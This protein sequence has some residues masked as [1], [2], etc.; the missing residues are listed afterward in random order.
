MHEDN[1]FFFSSGCFWFIVYFVIP[2]L[3]E[4]R[5]SPKCIRKEPSFSEIPIITITRKVLSLY[6]IPCAVTSNHL[7]RFL[8]S[9]ASHVRQMI[10]SFTTIQN[11]FLPLSTHILLLQNSIFRL[12]LS[13]SPSLMF[14][15]AFLHS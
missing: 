15:P 9:I 10:T 12:S 2:C 14:S 1:L 8:P 13:L 11:P 5:L 4:S 3:T 6:G 7:S